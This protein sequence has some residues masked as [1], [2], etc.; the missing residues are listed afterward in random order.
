M[1]SYVKDGIEYIDQEIIKKQ[2][3]VMGYM[4]KKIGVNIIMG[5]GIMNVSLPINIFDYRS[6]LET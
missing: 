1:K 6:L 3:G 5:K 4:V 2:R